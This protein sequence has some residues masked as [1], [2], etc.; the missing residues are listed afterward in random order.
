[1]PTQCEKMDLKESLN[2]YFEKKLFKE[3]ISLK[4]IFSVGIFKNNSG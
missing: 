3:P 2:L 1:M 4:M